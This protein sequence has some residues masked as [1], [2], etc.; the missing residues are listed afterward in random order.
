VLG[1]TGEPE[2]AQ[3]NIQDWLQQDE[4]GPGMCFLTE[5][6]NAAMIFFFHQHFLYY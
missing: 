1:A 4:G 5:E 3:E 6:E 2:T